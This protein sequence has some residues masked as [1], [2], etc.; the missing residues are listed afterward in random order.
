VLNAAEGML[1]GCNCVTSCYRCI[2]HYGN[3]W[4]HA[5]LDRHLALALIQHI[6]TG[7]VPVLD[8]AT[9]SSALKGLCEILRLRKHECIVDA[10]V[11]GMHVPLLLKGPT[12]A[13][14]FD[15]HHPLVDPNATPSPVTLA[16]RGRAIEFGS[17]DAFDLLHDLPAAVEQVLARG[18]AQ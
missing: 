7:H 3:N 13:R 14:W 8:E 15:V 18:S 17:V 10:D 11:R 2:R 12:G 5:S 1:A 4:I 6:R 9:K 16:A